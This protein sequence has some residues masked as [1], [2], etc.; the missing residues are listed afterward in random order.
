MLSLGWE[1]I[2]KARLELTSWDSLE[3]DICVDSGFVHTFVHI[4]KRWFGVLGN[5]L[6]AIVFN[7]TIVTQVF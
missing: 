1:M 7:L 4:L 5:K 2:A 6:V 3:S